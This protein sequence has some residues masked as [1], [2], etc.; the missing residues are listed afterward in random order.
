[1]PPP[2]QRSQPRR[3]VQTEAEAKGEELILAQLAC[4]QDTL[5]P[6]ARRLRQ[7]ILVRQR[8]RRLGQKPFDLDEWVKAYLARSKMMI[9]LEEHETRWKKIIGKE[10]QVKEKGEP[11]FKSTEEKTPYAHS[12]LSRLAGIPGRGRTTD[13]VGRARWNNRI[14]R[15]YIYREEQ[16]STPWVRLMQDIG[17]PGY[18]T[19]SLDYVHL[20][21]SL[22]KDVNDLLQLVF[23]PEIDMSSALLYPD[24]TV[25]AVYGRL[26]V[27]CAFLTP[28]GYITYIAVRPQWER[29]GIGEFMLWQLIQAAGTSMDIVIHVSPT[30]PA[31]ILY[32]RFGFKPEAFFVNFYDRYLAPTSQQCPNAFLMRLRR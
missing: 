2:S 16:A 10:D 6:E 22:L 13:K 1:M 32:Q 9:P 15:P 24:L 20:Q 14:L 18:K 7:K 11:R 23:W 12:F 28:E 26:V 4:L 29:G 21:R 30:N 5:K 27:G 17:G 25:V 8:K 19:R 3:R 31:M